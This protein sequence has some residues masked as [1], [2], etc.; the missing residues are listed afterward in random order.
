MS[1]MKAIKGFN[2]LKKIANVLVSQGLDVVVEG[3]KINSYVSFDQKIKKKRNAA[4]SHEIP[5]RLRKAMEDMGGAYVKLGQLLALRPD[6]IPQEYCKEFEKLLDNVKPFQFSSV[7]KIIESELGKPMSKVFSSFDKKPIAAASVGQVHK[8]KL[9]T[10]QIVAV[11]VQRP[12]IEEVFETDID[13][14]HYLAR[15][16]DKHFKELKPYRLIQLVKEFEEYTKKE[17]NYQV[18]AKNIEFFYQKE[19]VKGVKIPKVY[20]DYTKKKIIVME[21]IEGRNVMDCLN[22]LSKKEKKK[23]SREILDSLGRQILEYHMF[24]ADLHTGNIFLMKNKKVAFLDFGI[25]GKMSPI[26]REVMEE[27]MVGFVKKDIN[28]IVRGLMDLGTFEGDV[29]EQKFTEELY[30]KMHSFYGIELKKINVADFYTTV[31]TIIRKYNMQLPD[32][33]VLILKA[34]ATGET[35]ARIIDPDS[36]FV[37]ITRGHVEKIIERKKDP[38]NIYDTIK[39]HSYRWGNTLKRFPQDLRT[40]MHIVKTGAKVDVDIN[41]K[42]VDELTHEIGISSDRVTL[43]LIIGALVVGASLVMLAGIGPFIWGVP[44]ISYGMLFVI[45]ILSFGLVVSILNEKRGG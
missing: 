12:G 44:V 5:V 29:D 2:R 20:W 33:F 45:I 30:Q 25:V 13:I 35:V 16:G 22:E 42:E 39:S 40:L 14:L 15:Q 3:F 31:M 26:M 28:L 27:I 18:E 36:N 7:K 43:G 8:A 37:E 32:N 24:H 21:F 34:L 41:H 10:G 19:K 6:L 17:L 9:K 38:R 1:V 11:K 4:L 23:I